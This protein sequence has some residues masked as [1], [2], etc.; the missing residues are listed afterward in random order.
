[1]QTEKRVLK[2]LLTDDELIERGLEQATQ[3]KER[4]RLEVEKTETAAVFKGR[5]DSLK[6]EL[7][8]LAEVCKTRHEPREVECRWEP[9]YKRGRKALV[10]ADTGEV[11]EEMMLTTEERQGKLLS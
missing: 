4:C 5:I 8:R 10:R 6:L 1:M 3:H 11:V 9:D 7:D 2:C